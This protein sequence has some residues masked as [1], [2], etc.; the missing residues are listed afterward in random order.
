MDAVSLGRQV[1]EALERSYRAAEESGGRPERGFGRVPEPTD[2]D[3]RAAEL[4]AAELVSLGLVPGPATGWA[5]W[6][7]IS[8]FPYLR[9]FPGIDRRIDR[10][11]EVRDGLARFAVDGDQ[12]RAFVTVRFD[13]GWR[14]A[15]L[16][17]G[18]QEKED[19]EPP[20]S[21]TI[22]CPPERMMELKAFYK[23]LVNNDFPCRE[24][25]DPYVPPRWPD[26]AYPQQVHL[27]ILVADLDAGEAIVLGNGGSKLQDR[28][29]YRTYADP[30][31]HPLCLYADPLRGLSAEPG[32]AP[33][34]LARIVLDCADP[35]ELAIFYG[36][37]LRM[38][39][40]VE[41]SADRVVIARDAST[42]PML[43]FQRVADYRPPRWPDPAYP[44][45]MH[46][47][48][49]FDDRAAAERRATNLGATWLRPHN[50]EQFGHVY[51]D[52]AGHPF[53]LLEV[54]D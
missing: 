48:L 13:S 49:L 30:L 10:G 25:G 18:R 33:G 44:A 28:G 51:A 46:F 7:R 53:C 3:A 24:A 6:L 16:V 19:G 26:P 23:S 5:D 37:F 36:D 45:Q 38:T 27:D 9:Q 43:A 40:R 11:W 50:E 35:R 52:P 22:A 12:G 39:E 20:T 1:V 47:D 31:G 8:W 32:G 54:G 21:V 34:V 15:G 17:E 4:A 42:Y 14:L 2:V 41:D 29:T